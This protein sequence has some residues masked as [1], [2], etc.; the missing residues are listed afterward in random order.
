MTV[1][2]DSTQHCTSN[3]VFD[4]GVPYSSSMGIDEISLK[5]LDLI[6]IEYD[7]AE[8]SNS[9]GYTIHDFMCI[10]LVLNHGSTVIDTFPCIVR[11]GYVILIS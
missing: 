8:F 3:N 2:I 7:F 5:F 10:N 1:N 11:Y 9:G 4:H 6:W